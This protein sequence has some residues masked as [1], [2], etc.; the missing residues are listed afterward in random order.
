M[1]L[2][3]PDSDKNPTCVRCRGDHSHVNCHVK[4]PASFRCVN[5]SVTE[6]IEENPQFFA[7]LVSQNVGKYYDFQSNQGDISLSDT[8]MNDNQ[9]DES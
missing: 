5:C 7:N 3:C 4:D 9:N 8:E 6:S 1:K 2:N